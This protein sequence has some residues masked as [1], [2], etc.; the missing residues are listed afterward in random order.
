[1][2][3]TLDEKWRIN[4]TIKFLKRNKEWRIELQFPK[5]NNT[6]DEEK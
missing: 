6:K 4:Y 5:V 3:N 1:M 2:E